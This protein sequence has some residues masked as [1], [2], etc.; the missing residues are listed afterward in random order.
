MRDSE[1]ALMPVSCR[2]CHPEGDSVAAVCS[3]CRC[4]P[5]LAAVS[6]FCHTVVPGSLLVWLPVHS[7]QEGNNSW[8]DFTE[9]IKFGPLPQS[10]S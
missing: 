10:Q 6:L 4:V 9:I 3:R 1:A 8:R 5:P 2:G 7:A